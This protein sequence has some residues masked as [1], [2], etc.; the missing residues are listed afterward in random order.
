MK[1]EV[2]SETTTTTIDRFIS[3]IVQTWS[4]QINFRGTQGCVMKKQK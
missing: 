4:F 2:D 3:E 1:I